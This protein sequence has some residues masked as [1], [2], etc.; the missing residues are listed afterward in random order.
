MT[1]EVDLV[2]TDIDLDAVRPETLRSYCATGIRLTD[3]SAKLE[4]K[5]A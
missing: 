3:L 2:P 1:I 4:N 5:T